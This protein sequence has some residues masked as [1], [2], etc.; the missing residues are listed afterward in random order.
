MPQTVEDRCTD[1]YLEL[2]DLP[3]ERY[4]AERVGVVAAGRG[5][6]RAT[7]W[8]NA[9]PGR[10]DLPRRID[11][12]SLLGLYEVDRT[13]QP[14]EPE[15]D[16]TGFHFI[17][18]SRPGQGV[19]G[20]DDTDGLLLVLIS[21][22]HPEGSQALRDWADFVHIRHIAEVSVPGY[23]MITPYRNANGEDPLYLHLYEMST[24]DPEA[25]YRS[26]TPLVSERLGGEGSAAWQDWAFHPELRIVYVNTF[27]RVGV[28]VPN[29]G[30]ARG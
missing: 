22:R 1:L 30:E 14:P 29:K 8:S 20:D 4:A 21:P 6:E 27:R 3:P 9:N 19:L 11:E 2:T 12:F 17:R 26:M 7:W 24:K 18:T 13:F 23:R 28:I 5:V 15:I 25:A 16:V 10:Q